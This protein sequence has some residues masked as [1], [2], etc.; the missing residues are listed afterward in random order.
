MDCYT[1]VIE[2]IK[3]DSIDKTQLLNKKHIK[4]HFYKHSRKTID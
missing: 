4:D 3:I 2:L 1:I